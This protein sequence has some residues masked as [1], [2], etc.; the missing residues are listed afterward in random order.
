MITQIEIWKEL[1][2]YPYQQG[3][4][5]FHR[6]PFANNSTVKR[7]LW[8]TILEWVTSWE[9]FPCAH[10]WGQSALERLVLICRASQQSPWVVTGGPL[11]RGVIF[12]KILFCDQSSL[13]WEWYGTFDESLHYKLFPLPSFSSTNQTGRLSNEDD[14]FGNLIRQM[15]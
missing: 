5:S 6:S 12:V 1:I 11:G 15:S 3:A 8:G 10:E 7:V 9:V 2:N 4:S 13:S 14:L